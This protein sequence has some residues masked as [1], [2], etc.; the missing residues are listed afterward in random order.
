M[1]KDVLGHLEYEGRD[2]VKALAY[3]FNKPALGA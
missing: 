2:F 1:F 3:I